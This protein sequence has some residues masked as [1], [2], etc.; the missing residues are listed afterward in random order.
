MMEGWNNVTNLNPTFQYSL[1]AG[2]Q[3]IFHYSNLKQRRRI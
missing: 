1:P 2:R 3:A